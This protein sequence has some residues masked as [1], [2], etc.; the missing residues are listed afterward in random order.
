[1]FSTIQ[2]YLAAAGAILVM[3]FALIFKM[4]G[5]TIEELKVEVGSARAEVEV[6]NAVS[7]I[8]ADHEK[9]TDKLQDE[10]K[11]TEVAIAKETNS[12]NPGDTI[13]I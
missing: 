6:A 13:T 7:G 5:D 10:A 2:S 12:Y 8:V 11:D 4:R 1:M 3:G 9:F